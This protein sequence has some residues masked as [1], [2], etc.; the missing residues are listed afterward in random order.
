M[1][2]LTQGGIKKKNLGLLASERQEGIWLQDS[3]GHFMILIMIRYCR[4]YSVKHYFSRISF[5]VEMDLWFPWAE[6]G[7]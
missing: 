1:V 2:P 6:V 5:G 7:G 4:G 3:R